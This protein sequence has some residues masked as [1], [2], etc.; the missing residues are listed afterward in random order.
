MLNGRNYAGVGSRAVHV[1][2]RTLILV[3]T[4]LLTLSVSHAQADDGAPAADTG[5]D[6]GTDGPDTSPC[7]EAVA[8]DPGRAPDGIMPQSTVG[9]PI[10]LFDGSKHQRETDHAVPGSEL[11]LNRSYD[12]ANADFNV[13]LGQGWHHSYS[14]ALFD[15]GHGAREIVQSNGSR[16]RFEPDGQHEDGHELLRSGAMNEGHLLLVDDEHLWHLPDGRRLRFRGSFLVEIDWPDQRHL[17]LM[18]RDKKLASVTD[19]TGRVLRFRYTPGRRGL[20]GF[21]SARHRPQ[22]GTLHEVTLPDGQVIGYDYDERKNLTRVRYPDGTAREYHYEDTVWPNHLTGLTER[23]GVRIASWAYDEF[24]RA[25]L[26]EHAGGTK[27]VTLEH[28]DEQQVLDGE[29]VETR[30]T[31]SL[32]QVSTYVWRR[33]AVGGDPQLL[34]SSGPGCATCPPTGIAY[35][36]DDAGRL[37]SQRTTGLGTA[38][39]S[40][41]VDYRWDEQG[42]IAE[43]R[44]TDP[45]GVS[46]L[47]E[48][49]EYDGTDLV[50][51]NLVRPSVNP[52]GEKVIAIQRDEAGRPITITES[53]WSPVSDATVPGV[54]ADYRPIK[55]TTTRTYE[56]ARLVSIDGPRDDV[57]DIMAIDWDA[58]ERP[59]AVRLPDAPTLALTAFDEL[60]RVTA[61]RIGQQSP[62][63]VEYGPTHQAVRVEQRGRVIR[64]AYDAEGRL[65]SFTS[66]DGA[67]S[68]LHYDDA[69]TLSAL[70]DA[71]GRR[72]DIETDSEGRRTGSTELGSDGTMIRSVN[73]LFD[74]LGRVA[75]TRT[76]TVTASGNASSR[77][78]DR[79]YDEAGRLSTVT[80]AGTGQQVDLDYGAFGA[81]ASVTEPG[82]IGGDDDVSLRRTAFEHDAAG[83]EIALVDARG[84]RT[85]Y[86]ADD[87]G[88]VVTHVAPDTG[89]TRYRYDLAGNRT[90]KRDADGA[91]IRYRWDAAGRMIGKVR[92]DG[93]Y[94][95]AYDPDHGQLIESVAPDTTERFSFDGEGRLT[96]HARIL[97]ERR[98]ET[99]YRYDANGRISHKTLPDGQRLRYHYRDE[100]AGTARGTLR[101]ITRDALFGLARETLVGEIDQDTSDGASGYIAGNGLRTAGTY[102]VDGSLV[103]LDVDRVMALEYTFDDGGRIVGLDVDGTLRRYRYSGQ[104]LSVAEIGDSTYRFDYDATGNRT[105]DS[106]ER[107]DGTS[108]ATT[109]TYPPDGGGN[110]L[111]ES[112][113]LRGHATASESPIRTRDSR[114]YAEGGSPRRARAGLRY[115]Y[116]SERRPIKV[117]E[118]DALLA[119]YA[120]NGFGERIKKVTYRGDAKRVTWFLYDGHHLTAQIDGE[121]GEMRQG[122]FLGEAPVAYLIGRDAYAVHGDHL[123]APRLATDAEG[124]PVWAADYRPFGQAD[125]TA[126]TIDLPYRLPGQILDAETGTHYNYY[127]DYD[128]ATGRYLTSDPIGLQGGLNTY[129]YAL[130]DPLGMTDVLG[131]FPGDN[132]PDASNA[133]TGGEPVKPEEQSEQSYADK[134]TKVF[135]YAIEELSTQ[136]GGELAAEF[137]QGLV[138]N[139][140]IVAGVVVGLAV[141]NAAGVGAAATAILAASG[142]LLAGYEAGRFLLS[143]IQLGIELAS[144]DLCDEAAL[145][146]QGK[147]LANSVK[148][149]GRALTESVLLGSLTRIGR[150]VDNAAEYAADGAW[151]LWRRLR[152]QFDEN[153]VVAGLC[154]FSGDTLVSTR[155]GYRA[156]RDIEP[157]LDEVWAKDE[158]TGRSGWRQVLAQYGNRYEDTVRV[159]ARDADG[160]RQ[161]IVSNRI[162]PYFARLAASAL[163]A[164]SSATAIA[165]EGHVYRGEIDGGAWVDAQHLDIGDE[166]L[167][168]RNGWQTIEH[169][170]IEPEP[171]DA[172]N[173]T[174]DEYS[175]YF[176]A[177]DAE[178][179]PVWVHNRCFD[180][181]PPGFVNRSGEQTA[182]GQPIFRHDDGSVIYRGHDGRFYD[183]DDHPPT[184][185]GVDGPSRP[186]NEVQTQ[187]DN[188]DD[189]NDTTNQNLNPN[190]L[191]PSSD[192]LNAN[193][194]TVGVTRPPDTAAHHIVPKNPRDTNAAGRRALAILRR[195]GVNIDEAV[196]GVYLPCNAGVACPP[197]TTHSSMHTNYYF[198]ELAARLEAVP[199]SGVRAEL[200]KIARELANGT[201]RIAE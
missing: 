195:A 115:E 134:L 98:F 198:D 40:G 24:G 66:P 125:V 20:D 149:L 110:R 180:E 132:A 155:D 167:T 172:Y 161:T 59:V 179:S 58:R 135:E 54:V 41:Q 102:A 52:D 103:S 21:E 101:A 121:S 35:T 108:E 37:E 25:R 6:A 147:T 94:T 176:V 42:R 18:Y 137:L 74:A 11:V 174:V 99:A 164:T 97:D 48:R 140:A 194:Q 151:A 63:T 118:D 186:P 142:W 51:R 107:A 159:T 75:G 130:N 199:L 87:F 2:R 117:F 124:E 77:T 88:R 144:T 173:L 49:T 100:T 28:P 55:R 184:R 95:Y 109:H 146:T 29:R 158:H 30:V 38:I 145:Q 39:D 154:S 133:G 92:P 157:G 31:D 177:G 13:G 32:G 122:I 81:L 33:P 170:V 193:L 163:I 17:S 196:N 78:L 26:S 8:T 70:V 19:E 15:A 57:A 200:Q 61:F 89:T 187:F 67:T 83:N 14:V 111:L 68:R 79:A 114:D 190:N 183:I 104:G 143:T 127:R 69:G 62:V 56:G 10:S 171:L 136:D 45:S 85:L 96:R 169:V 201:F 141:A 188:V 116:D 76:E 148:D 160:R 80:D 7:T 1:S 165:S 166:L 9:N 16:L 175:T 44:R 120:Y 36:Y 23:T 168:D 189:I 86:L 43:I 138:E 119:T 46:R 129:A 112:T 91:V 73:T 34:S 64:F 126:A 197:S 60:G 53:G 192:R 65:T 90:E 150:L 152:R 178:A 113:T 22:P 4:G 139:I 105:A 5:C 3:L 71:K 162:H 12:S 123:G 27:R 156:I 128:P 182:F 106:I 93:A 131:L 185:D 84:N 181:R 72:T 82:D 50:P 47:V 153:T 191:P